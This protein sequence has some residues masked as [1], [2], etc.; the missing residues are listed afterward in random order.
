MNPLFSIVIP[1]YNRSQSMMPTLQSVLD[2]TCTDYEC[3]IVDDGSSDSEALKQVIE[4]LGDSRFRYVWRENGGGGAARNTGILA[5]QGKY[6]AFLDSDDLFLPHKLE[7]CQKHITDDPL[8]GIYSFMY[9]DRGVQKQWV[10]PNRA[11]GDNEDMGAYLFIENEF[12]QTSTIVLHAD[13][14]RKTL[15][16]PTLRKG[17]DL[18]FCLRLHHDN[19][20][21]T[22]I[23]QPLTVWVDCTEVGRT[24]RV[25]GYEAPLAWLEH[26]RPF[27]TKNA[28]LG[29]R[30]TVLFYYMAKAKPLTA[31]KDLLKGWLIAKVPTRVIARQFLRGF[32]PKSFYR[33]L[34][35]MFVSKAGEKPP[36]TANNS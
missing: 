28:E 32:L 30:A 19:V 2:Q 5:A 35:N 25:K 17:Q 9:V 21:F 12:I 26:A 27:L 18:D 15:F 13:A 14:A 6:I 1:V 34:V 4:G 7:T 20:R 36:A 33:S 16:D 10:R 23:E 8:H 22:A 31:L 24:S 29:Y 3:I 11:I